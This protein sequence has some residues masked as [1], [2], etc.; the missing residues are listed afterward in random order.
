M[1]LNLTDPILAFVRSPERERPGEL[2]SPI[3]A[4][5]SSKRDLRLIVSLND[6]E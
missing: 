1:V 5:Q 2:Q 6:T 4:T 3:I